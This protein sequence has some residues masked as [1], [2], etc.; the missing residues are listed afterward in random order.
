MME[1]LLPAIKAKWPREDMNTPMYIQQD[2][3]PSH[4]EVDDLL[5]CEAAQEDGFNIRLKCQPPNSPYF[6]ILDLGI[7]FVPYNQFSIKN[8][9]KQCKT[10]FQ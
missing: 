8:L 7:F 2:N 9:Q 10:L 5:F 1:N 6:N 4:I 3:T